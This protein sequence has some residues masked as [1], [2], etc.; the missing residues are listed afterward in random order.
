MALTKSQLEEFEFIAGT[1]DLGDDD[2][3]D[4]ENVY[5]D[6]VSETCIKSLVISL[7]GVLAAEED[8]SATL[9]CF[10]GL[11]SFGLVGEF[12]YLF[13]LQGHEKSHARRS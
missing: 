13:V 1:H 3:D 5:V 7:I 6:W 8:S 12:T 2:D 9:V 4:D 10:R 11:D